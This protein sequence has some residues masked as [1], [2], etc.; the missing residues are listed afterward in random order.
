[1]IAVYGKAPSR[2]L[3]VL[4]ML[5]E[6]GL[7]Y[8]V[9]GVDFANRFADTEFMAASPAGAM[10]GIVDGDVSMMESIAILQYLAARRGPTS[11]DVKPEEPDYPAYLQWLHFGEASVMA[12]LNVKIASM[13]FAP[14]EHRDN[15][16]GGYAV[17]MA[18]KRAAVLV[19]RLREHEFLAADRFTAAD[20]SCGYALTVA[21]ALGF[22]DRLDPA[23]I[24]Y[25]DRV[26]G[27][28]AFQRAKDAKPA[29]QPAAA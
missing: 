4:W 22:E 16:G 6:M 20:I 28:P 26:T 24:A 14:E 12:P 25:R 15:W 17:S 2:A 13:W 23:V 7:A 27:R 5:E 18:A 11:L 3:R 19:P 9:R 29:E 8:E 1:M 21:A 10:P